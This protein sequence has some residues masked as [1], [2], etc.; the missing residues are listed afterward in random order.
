MDKSDNITMGAKARHPVTTQML[1]YCTSTLLKQNTKTVSMSVKEKGNKFET[2]TLC[3]AM[4]N[5][6]V[7]LGTDKYTHWDYRRN[8]CYSE[9]QTVIVLL[10]KG[11]GCGYKIK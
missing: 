10:G 9:I 3:S 11:G 6:S 7:L 2:H 4:K 1:M 8:S 5:I